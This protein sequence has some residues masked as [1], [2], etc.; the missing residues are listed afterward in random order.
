MIRELT[1]QEM[2]AVQ[3]GIDPVDIAI[4]ILIGIA[5]NKIYDDLKNGKEIEKIIKGKR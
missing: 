4:G 2:M 5:A 1:E 3:G